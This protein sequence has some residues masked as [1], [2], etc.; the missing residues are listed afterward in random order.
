[1]FGTQQNAGH[2]ITNAPPLSGVD[3]V[4][5]P[6]DL[7][8]LLTSLQSV[9]TQAST[10]GELPEETGI[11]VKAALEKAALQTKKLTPEKKSILDY[12][13]TAKTL[14]ESVSAASAL[15]PSIVSAMEAVHKLF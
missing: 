14:I 7:V 2:D 5:N 6:A 8:A 12:L 10:D 3:A 4:R 9:V 11:E 15:V 1:V 13:T